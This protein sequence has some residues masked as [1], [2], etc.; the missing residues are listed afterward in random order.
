MSEFKAT[1]DGFGGFN[2]RPSGT[3]GWVIL[4][5]LLF[6]F[7]PLLMIVLPVWG[8]TKLVAVFSK[9]GYGAAFT[10]TLAISALPGFLTLLMSNI[11]GPAPNT[12][13]LVIGGSI[14][15]LVA[16]TAF[17]VYPKR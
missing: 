17:I 2:I 3:P 9:H 5:G 8:L 6:L 12:D 1:P 15:F 16:L 14:T 13:N 11:T 7:L 4:I 10:W